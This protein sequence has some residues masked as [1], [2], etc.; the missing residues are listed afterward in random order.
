MDEQTH[1]HVC[2]MSICLYMYVCLYACIYTCMC[3][4]IPHYSHYQFGSSRL[5]S[6]KNITFLLVILNLGNMSVERM[7]QKNKIHEIGK[8]SQLKG[9]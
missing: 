7:H 6:L 5:E 1:L 4:F 8:C 2:I 3:V 9:T